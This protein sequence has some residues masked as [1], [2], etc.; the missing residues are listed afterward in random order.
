M[1]YN[2]P[3]VAA[4]VSLGI[5][6]FSPVGVETA[7]S[8]QAIKIVGTGLDDN[9]IQIQTLTA[10]G[11]TDQTFLWIP[12]D[13]ASGYGMTGEGWF[14]MDNWDVADKSFAEGEAYILINN[15]G[16]GVNVQYCGEVVQGATQ[17]PMASDVSMSGNMTPKEF[18]I[19]AFVV[20]GT[21]L[22]DNSI[23]IQT[24]TAGGATDQTFLW[25]PADFASGYGMSGE[26]WFDM[27]NWDV[28]DKDFAAA[29][30]FVLI[31]NVGDG[32]TLTI[33]SALE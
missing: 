18:S 1:G 6:S 26:G 11:A 9:S 22:D 14:D 30:G 7:T 20:D 2:T 27:D 31:N 17:I 25:I 12:A 33:P 29:E 24:L 19:Q 8:I 23:Q 4:D 21:G 3:D 13:Y 16:S 28:A 5:S 10:G 15:V 32:P